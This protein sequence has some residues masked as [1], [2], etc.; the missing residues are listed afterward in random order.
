MMLYQVIIFVFLLCC[1]GLLLY[2]AG[3]RIIITLGVRNIVLRKKYA[4]LVILGLMIGTAVITSSLV[5]GDT[6][7]TMMESEVL[8][9]YHTIDEKIVG[10]KPT[11]ERDYFSES[12]FDD[13]E[14]SLNVSFIDGI[15]PSIRDRVAVLNLETNLSDP[16]VLLLGVDFFH[17]DSFG[18]FYTLQGNQVT[19]LDG[20]ECMMNE[21]TATELNAGVGDQIVLYSQGKYRILFLSHILVSRER[22]G[23]G[24]G[25]FV[26]LPTAQDILNK[27]GLINEILISNRGGVRD[28]LGYTDDVQSLI[29]S[30]DFPSDLDFHLGDIKKRTLDEN[31][32]NMTIFTDMFLVF[33]SFSIIAGIIL[34]INIFVML[35]EERKSEMGM[36]RAIG[37]KRKH[38]KKMYLSE[39]CIYAVLSSLTGVFLGVGIGFIIMSAVSHI[40]HGFGS[41][42]IVQYFTVTPLSVVLGFIS[43]FLITLGTIYFTAH[44]ISHLNIVRAIRDIPEPPVMRSDNRILW[45]GLILAVFSIILMAMA[46]FTGQASLL[47]TGLSFLLFSLGLIIRRYIGDRWAFTGVSLSILLVWFL[48]SSWFPSYT[49]GIEMFIFSGLFLIVAC[50]L[51]VMCNSVQITQGIMFLIGWGKSMQAVLK[52]A[53]SYSLRSR[54]RT[55]MTIA[56]FALIIFSITIMSMIVGIVGTNIGDQVNKSAGGYDILAFSLP[57]SPIMNISQELREKDLDSF[58]ENAVGVLGGPITLSLSSLP[59]ETYSYTLVGINN[60]F[61]AGSTFRF[62]KILDPYQDADEVWQALRDNSSHIIIDAT[63]LGTQFGL[64]SPFTIDVGDTL[65]LHDAKNET[66]EKKI[67]AILDTTLMQ[68]L[69]SFE[70]HVQKDFGFT[71]PTFF[72]FNVKD[73]VDVDNL[74]KNIENSFLRYGLQVLD[75]EN[76]V[77]EAVHAM[78]QFFNLFE[79]FMA[80]GLVIGIAGLGIITIRSVHERRQEI[81]MMRALGF[82]RKMV[83]YSF[84]IE[85]SFVALIGITIGV[86]LGVLIGFLVWRDEFA[87]QGLDFMINWQPILIMS[88]L[89]FFVTLL[90]IIP[91]SQKASHVPPAEALRYRG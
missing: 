59:N 42:N 46:R 49:G 63:V 87:I 67:I 56:I 60:D 86:I 2:L 68:A 33:G 69:F 62:E 13:L 20:T 25:L 3:E 91:A 11:G 84:I 8:D 36:V 82:K 70:S 45:L 55:G 27:T 50:L 30:L 75:L 29:D 6:M 61:I 64:P 80:M 57:S 47:F 40:L 35:A 81:G 43:G 5:V 14:I 18:D 53:I 9:A 58:L 39:G 77:L 24:S 72:L 10:I 34:I 38:L 15:S 74:S 7:T 4:V 21:Q 65:L 19:Q 37:M 41:I 73:D 54:F 23:T 88:L 78:N 31:K 12:L 26:T 79:S 32:E 44:R 85:T 17:G 83:L 28:G 16:R 71:G 22:G 66:H 48:P 76:L 90:C 52:T 1:L 89:S 51:L